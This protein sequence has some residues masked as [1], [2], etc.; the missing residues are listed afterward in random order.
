MSQKQESD[1]SQELQVR[2][3]IFHRLVECFES[4]N[5][6]SRQWWLAFLAS[7]VPATE[8][9]T[10]AGLLERVASSP[11]GQSSRRKKAR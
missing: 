8:L 9:E 3:A 11:V 5:Q 7:L 1:N 4:S 10:L 2:V 6:H